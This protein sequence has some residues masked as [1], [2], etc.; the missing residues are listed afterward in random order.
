MATELF[1]DPEFIVEAVTLSEVIVQVPDLR[2]GADRV[3][4]SAF[5]FQRSRLDCRAR[6]QL[7]KMFNQHSPKV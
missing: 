2:A 3:G 6:L 7:R 4:R 1:R 5:R